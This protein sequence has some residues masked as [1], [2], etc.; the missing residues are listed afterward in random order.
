VEAQV[1]H[2]PQGRSGATP[3]VRVEDGEQNGAAFTFETNPRTQTR[4]PMP[5]YKT[6]NSALDKIVSGAGRA[7]T[8][9]G[10]R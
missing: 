10:V 9:A 7:K 8:T 3:R 2:R 5:A 1:I 6:P 4:A